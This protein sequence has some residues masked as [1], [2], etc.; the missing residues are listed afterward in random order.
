M[1]EQ[2]IKTWPGLADHVITYIATILDYLVNS[3]SAK[4]YITGSELTD[5]DRKA[6]WSDFVRIWVGCQSLATCAAS[7]VL[8]G[9]AGDPLAPVLAASHRNHCS[10]WKSWRALPALGDVLP[11]WYW[12][13]STPV[14][15]TSCLRPRGGTSGWTSAIAH[16]LQRAQRDPL[17][18]VRSLHLHFHLQA[19]GWCSLSRLGFKHQ[20]LFALHAI[21]SA[22]PRQPW[23]PLARSFATAFCCFC[24]SCGRCHGL[25]VARVDLIAAVAFGSISPRWTWYPLAPAGTWVPIASRIYIAAAVRHIL[26]RGQ[27][28]PLTPIRLCKAQWCQQQE[29]QELHHVSVL[30]ENANLWNA[31]SPKTAGALHNGLS[32]EFEVLV[33]CVQLPIRMWCIKT[34]S[35]KNAI[36]IS[37][38]K[39]LCVPQ[40][41]WRIHIPAFPSSQHLSS[42][43]NKQ[44]REKGRVPLTPKL[45]EQQKTTL[46]HW[47]GNLAV[48]FWKTQR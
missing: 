44:M 33:N 20:R 36:Q 11:S 26:L 24:H 15:T 6:S 28:N 31:M 7:H 18:P 23:E 10:F 25:V 38:G 2:K 46:L 39:K 27:G 37:W 3:K 12:A 34:S 9:R 19:R 29:R 5:A 35:T 45:S 42:L 1:A 48:D 40:Q 4:L 22:V 43:S 41:L 17:A 30:C 13:P 14:G 16:V 21:W 32:E 47:A 8:P